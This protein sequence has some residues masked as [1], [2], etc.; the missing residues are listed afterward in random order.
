MLRKLIFIMALMSTAGAGAITLVDTGAGPGAGQ[1]LFP[2]CSEVDCSSLDTGQWLAGQVTFDTATL[3]TDIRGWLIWDP[4]IGTP[5]P[6]EFVSVN[7]HSNIDGLPGE[8]LMS[9]DFFMTQM[10]FGWYGPSNLDWSLDAGTYWFSFGRSQ[11]TP[12]FGMASAF[13]VANPLSGNA[14]S[15]EGPDDW[16]LLQPDQTLALQIEGSQV[17]VPGILPHA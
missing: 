9:T 14:F 11:P 12:N 7:I 3:I 15:R 6:G 17:P 10:M 13:G 8:I 16:A 5:V 1:P 4:V 2:V